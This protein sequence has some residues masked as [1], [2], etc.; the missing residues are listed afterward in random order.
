MLGSS[1]AAERRDAASA[2]SGALEHVCPPPGTTVDV[3]SFLLDHQHAIG[4]H[5]GAATWRNVQAMITRYG[6]VS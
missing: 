4:R 5:A 2:G 6:A 3:D 1:A